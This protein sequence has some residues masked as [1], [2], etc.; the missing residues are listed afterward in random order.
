M[1]HEKE[2]SC[3]LMTDS[4]VRDLYRA[5]A[6]ADRDGIEGTLADDVRFSRPVDVGRDRHGYLEGGW[7]G[8][9]TRRVRVRAASGSRRRRDRDL[10]MKRPTEARAATPRSSPTKGDQIC[11]VDVSFGWNIR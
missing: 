10:E 7:P 1:N 5:L 2:E 8:A 4:T 3:R 6:S 11:A 9:G